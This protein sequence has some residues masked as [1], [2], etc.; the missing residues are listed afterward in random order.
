MLVEIPER[1]EQGLNVLERAA[2]L[3]AHGDAP[4]LEHIA[5]H[6]RGAA[7]VIQGRYSEA[8]P[9]LRRARSAAK[10]ELSLEHEILSC[11]NEG[12]SH[13]ALGDREAAS[14]D[15]GGAVGRA[16]RAV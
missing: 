15:R 16:D 6:N 10:G 7:L 3:L 13:V 4:S 5:E 12:L 9:H 11:M 14:R 2:T 8:A 1:V